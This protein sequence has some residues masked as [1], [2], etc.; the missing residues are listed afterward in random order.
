MTVSFYVQD[1]GFWSKPLAHGELERS[2]TTSQQLSQVVLV[3]TPMYT[4]ELNHT[5]AL[6][7]QAQ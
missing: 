5:K 2:C 1:W 4:A 6:N 3:T 7:H